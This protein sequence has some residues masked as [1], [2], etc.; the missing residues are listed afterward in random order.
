[1]MGEID[2]QGWLEN[3]G[4]TEL[5]DAKYHEQSRAHYEKVAKSL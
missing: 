3:N 2:H 1:M 4:I 5:L